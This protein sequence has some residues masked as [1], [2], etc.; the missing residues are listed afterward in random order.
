VNLYRLPDPLRVV[1]FDID[2]TLYENPAYAESQHR[3]LIEELAD[4]LGVSP[5]EAYRQV[6]AH[7]TKQ[8]LEHAGRRPSLAESSAALGFDIATSVE[9]RLRRIAPEDYLSPDERLHG[10]LRKLATRFTVAAITNNPVEI[11]RRSL[12]ALGIADSFQ[13][14]VGLDSTHA[15]KPNPL[16]FRYLADTL[17]IPI[18]EILIVGDRYGVDLEPALE[19]G[20][21][22]VLVEGIRDTYALCE[23]LGR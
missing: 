18:A 5:E 7:K 10:L 15:S 11:G 3:V 17:Q 4:G 12:Q 21:G 9:W 13:A 16:P 19:L 6:D 1:A 23:L 22:A 8:A 20:G 14:V 2:N